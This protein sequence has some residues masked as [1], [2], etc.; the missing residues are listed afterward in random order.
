MIQ[1]SLFWQLPHNFRRRLY[2]MAQPED[3]A[4]LNN[5]RTLEPE[6]VT[7]P[8]FKPFLDT[9]TLFVHIPKTAG[10]AIGH[11]VYGRHTGNHTT[12]A[13]YQMAFSRQEFTAMF[14]FT[15]VRNPWDRLLSAYQFMKKGGRNEGDRQWSADHLASFTNFEAFV[16]GWVNP[17]NVLKGIHFTPQHHFLTNP[18][19]DRIMVDFVGRFENL[20]ADWDAL[21]TKVKVTSTLEP[22]NVNRSADD[23]H[24]QHYTPKMVER[25][26]QVYAKDIALFGYS[27]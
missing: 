3:Y 20:Q 23:D 21:Q 7:A 5:Y 22:V 24:R 1:N 11:G 17:E 9:R 2:K 14:T 12:I 13:E 16:L 19:S 8:T 18:G 27:F 4:R 15:F 26:R 25:V 6:K 10:I